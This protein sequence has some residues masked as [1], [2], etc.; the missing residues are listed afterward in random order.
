MSGKEGSNEINIPSKQ[1]E[2]KNKSS[3]PSFSC[4]EWVSSVWKFAKEDT[5]RVLF[6]LKMGLAVL[7]V[8]L[9]ILCQA[10][11]RVL[12]IN[13]VWAILT[14]AIVF[15]H[16][17]G[18]TLK[19]GFN[20]AFGTIVSGI[21]AIAIAIAQLA[22]HTGRI[23][24]PIVIGV[25]IFI[26]V[27]I[28]NQTRSL[29]SS[30]ETNSRDNYPYTDKGLWFSNTPNRSRGIRTVTSFMK[31]LPSFGPYEAGFR[32]IIFTYGLIIVSGCRLGNPIRTALD[33][34][35]SIAIGGI[36]AVAVNVFIFP[37][38]AGDQLHKEL[39]N[40]L[41][42]VADALEECVKK[43]LEDDGSEHEEFSKTVMDEFPDEPAYRKCKSTLISSAKLESLGVSAKWEPPHGRFKHFFYPWL[44][45]VKVGA[46]LSY[47]AYEVMALHGILH[48]KIQAPYNLRIT[49][50]KEIQE[51]TSDAAELVRELGKD[52]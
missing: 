38:W 7:L 2:T 13:T 29:F 41:N 9:L 20:R 10:R 47:C 6:S 11:Y 40:N 22:L 8:S 19:R 32:V 3:K 42:S 39:V 36:I 48:S 16:T 27:K 33:R 1:R 24:E 50:Q 15:E 26:V 35:S 5:N 4:K 23:A 37:I 52:M 28:A 46:V 12:G 21:L 51:A 25:S 45:Y 18:A 30:I 49:F 14:V 43:Y 34:L 31:L 44:E 17:V